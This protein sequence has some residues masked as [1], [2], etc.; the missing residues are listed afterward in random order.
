M[1]DVAQHQRHSCIDSVD[2]M[3]LPRGR[4]CLPGSIE[5]QSKLCI[6][7]AHAAL[8]RPYLDSEIKQQIFTPDFI[9]QKH[10]KI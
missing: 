8:S 5:S 1:N 4:L 6:N 3:D 2:I 7:V 9:A 10:V